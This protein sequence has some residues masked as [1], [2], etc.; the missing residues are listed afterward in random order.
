MT[1]PSSPPAA[2][3]P[4]SLF[5]ERNFAQFW[6]ARV[7]STVAYAMQA[8][9]LGWQLYAITGSAFD[10]GL[11]GLVQFVPM[12]FLTLV[13]GHM[14]DRYDRRRIVAICQYIEAGCAAVLVVGTAGGWLGREGILALAAVIGSARAFEWPTMSALLPALVTRAQLQN[15]TA[16]ATTA[17]Q[18]AQILGPAFGGFLYAL[19]ALAAYGTAAILFL[20]A[21]TL[22]LLLRTER[23]VRRAEPVTLA[24]VFSGF[25]FIRSR[26][27]LLGVLSLDLFAVLLGGAVALLPVYARDILG[28][29]PWGLGLLRAAPA[30]GAVSM[31]VLLARHRLPGAAGPLL[32]GAVTLFGI[33][34][35]V[36]GL[37]TWLPLSLAALAV[38]GASDVVS[39]VI[40]FSLVQLQ[41]PDEMRGRVSAVNSFFI[42]TSN[43]LGEF[44]SGA[45][46]ALIGV[47]PA[48]VFGG[49]GTI[50]VALIWMV[51]FPELRR[52]RTLEG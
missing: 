44:E 38:L 1:Q 50:A 34:T 5:S 17:N 25:A 31:S 3:P 51:L 13:V 19:S 52:L 11:I 47:V 4:A 18:T 24:S 49:V 12:V 27:V 45:L 32:F 28:T 48:V 29:G 7:F 2:P 15:A 43:Q 6:L 14:A 37:S 20:C 39:V 36:F 21:G 8:V 41:T 40:R 23:H 9:A 30:V 22:T 33:A 42:G 10:L 26:R 35:T 46:A 16:W